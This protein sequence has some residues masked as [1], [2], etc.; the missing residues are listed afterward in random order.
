[1]FEVYKNEG[2]KIKMGGCNEIDRDLKL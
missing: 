1:M 2:M